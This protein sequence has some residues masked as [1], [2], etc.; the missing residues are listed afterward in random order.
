MAWWEGGVLKSYQSYLLSGQLVTLGKCLSY[1]LKNLQDTE[2]CFEQWLVS[3]CLRF[4][5]ICSFYNSIPFSCPT[6]FDF[7]CQRVSW[8]FFSL[9]TC[10]FGSFVLFFVFLF[11]WIFVV[12]LSFQSSPPSAM[13]N[14]KMVFNPSKAQSLRPA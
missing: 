4:L 1:K 6:S 8:F 11:C 14:Q 13:V 2:D 5:P 12:F 7:C 10:V 3:L 9:C